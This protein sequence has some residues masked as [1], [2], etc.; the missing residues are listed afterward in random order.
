MEAARASGLK[1][2][3]PLTPLPGRFRQPIGLNPDIAPESVAGRS[4]D[5][6]PIASTG[7]PGAT[8]GALVAIQSG[9]SGYDGHSSAW[10]TFPGLALGM[11]CVIGHGRSAQLAGRRSSVLGV[12]A[13][14]LAWNGS[15]QEQEGAWRSGACG[16]G[17]CRARDKPRLTA[18]RTGVDAGIHDRGLRGEES[19]IEVARYIVAN[20]LRA[21]LTDRIGDYPYWDSVW[22]SPGE[23]DISFS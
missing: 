22:L 15:T 9:L 21:G 13:R 7:L 19:L 18:K 14:P 2:L 16:E 5:G 1:P 10:A 4:R 20:P 12:D 8:Q 23:R 6:A 3:P 17:A 11:H